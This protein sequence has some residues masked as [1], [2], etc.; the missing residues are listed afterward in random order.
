[1]VVRAEQHQRVCVEG[2]QQEVRE[3]DEKHEGGTREKEEEVRES[4]ELRDDG[5]ER[6]EIPYT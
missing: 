1:M 3:G 2:R 5:E 4:D 6:E